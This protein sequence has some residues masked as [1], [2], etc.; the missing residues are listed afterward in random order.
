MN[1][2]LEHKYLRLVSG[3]LDRW[4]EK[5]TSPHLSVCR[6]PFCGDSKK[7]Q[8]KTRFYFYSKDG[9]ILAHCHNCDYH[10][11]FRAFLREFDGI[12]YKEMS[13]ESLGKKQEK[14]L[15]VFQDRKKLQST[16]DVWN[17]VLTQATDKK[18][19]IAF[20]QKRQI[21]ESKWKYIYFTENFAADY[22]ELC[23]KL[24]I[25]EKTTV[26][27][28]KTSGIVF[29]FIT[30]DNILTHCVWRNLDASSKFR[31]CNIELQNHYKIFG[32]DRLEKD[33]K[34]IY[35]CEGP[36]DSLF[37]DNCI[38]TGDAALDKAAQCFDKSRLV[39]IADNE[40]LAPVQTKRIGTFLERGFN[41]VLFPSTVK[42]KDLNEMHCNG[43]NIQELVDENTFFGLEGKLRFQQWKKI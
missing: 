26:K 31:Y 38:A 24:N 28:P 29:P 9:K 13:L 7:S 33:C 42:G 16:K 32:A 21:P 35:V 10:K 6:C 18:E 14:S 25:E 11:T 39:L 37:L 34:K 17:Q 15:F 43:Y 3:K 5:N 27:L 30:Q 8:T 19:A 4:Q 22:L 1:E 20:L 36:I 12:L 2:Y 23:K 41:V 40:P